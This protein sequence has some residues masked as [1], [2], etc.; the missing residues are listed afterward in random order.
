MADENKLNQ[1][2]EEY[3]RLGK[4]HKDVNVAALMINALE[5]AQRDEMEQS[6]KK[7]AYLVSLFLP[8]L[9]Y[10]AALW[11][12][13]QDKPD[14]KKV[15]LNCAIITSISLLFSWWFMH[16]I[17]SV[18]PADTSAQLQG[19]KGIQQVKDLQDLVGQ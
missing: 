7:K 3:A 1:Q 10:L 4:E 12:L 2:M 5:Q 6:K 18:V 16:A 14:A 9:G 15:A 17:S 19:A 8:P 13:Y 11:V